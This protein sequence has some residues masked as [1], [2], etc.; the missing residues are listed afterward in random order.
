MTFNLCNAALFPLMMTSLLMASNAF[1]Q[2][3][4]RLPSGSS[5]VTAEPA[6]AGYTES[7]SLDAWTRFLSFKGLDINTLSSTGMFF[8]N[9]SIGNT[10][11]GQAYQS[12]TNL[13]PNESLPLVMASLSNA[14]LLDGSQLTHVDGLTNLTYMGSHL[15]LNGNQLTNVDG[16]SQLTFVN[17]DLN[18]MFNQLTNVDGLISLT[19]VGS[20]LLL[21]GNLLT[22]V[23]GLAN[24]ASVGGIIK[25]D[26]AYAGAKLAA[27]TPFCSNM[28]ASKFN[29]TTNPTAYAVK[30]QVCL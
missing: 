28:V 20:N 25:I 16:L 29:G 4:I 10:P 6:A 30:S 11:T 14:I 3:E 27:S 7:E 23:S 17:N 24:I 9:H 15:Y 5:T 1:A 8:S 2:Y 22:T 19:H 18:L 13:L 12:N 26:A 21:S